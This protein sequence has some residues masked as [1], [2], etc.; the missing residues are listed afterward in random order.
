M[1]A[2]LQY[3][4]EAAVTCAIIAFTVTAIVR[5]HAGAKLRLED[6]LIRGM[7]ASAIPTGFALLLSAFDPSLLQKMS[8]FNIH[9]ATAGLALIYI[10][11]KSVFDKP[12]E[13]EFERRPSP[14]PIPD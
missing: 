9:I 12:K 7:A 13:M 11:L 8:G 3:I 10:S 6:L 14:A 1:V 5:I 2:I 4:N